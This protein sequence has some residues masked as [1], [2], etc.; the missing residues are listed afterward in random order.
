[1]F[2]KA[3][4][5]S[6]KNSRLYGRHSNKRKY[7]KFP[8]PLS[9]HQIPFIKVFFSSFLLLSPFLNGNESKENIKD[10]HFSYFWFKGRLKSGGWAPYL[11]LTYWNS[12]HSFDLFFRGNN[13][14]KYVRNTH[15]L[16][17]NFSFYYS[18]AFDSSPSSSV[19]YTVFH[20][21]TTTTTLCIHVNIYVF[22][23]KSRPFI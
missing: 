12:Y 6:K 18:A 17:Y 13:K 4:V 23:C 21:S 16:K 7:T 22:V 14:Q 1:M 5:L 9:D 20:P 8:N 11:T 19:P 2:L 3:F 10:T 15:Y